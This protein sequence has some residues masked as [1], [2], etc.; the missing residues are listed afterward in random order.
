MCVV[1]PMSGN[2][3]SEEEV[4]PLGSEIETVLASAPTL[5]KY[6]FSLGSV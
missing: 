5:A 6:S 2:E 3:G 1:T 4:D